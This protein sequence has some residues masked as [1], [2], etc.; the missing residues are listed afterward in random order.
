MNGSGAAHGP[1]PLTAQVRLLHP[2]AEHRQALQPPPHT[3]PHTPHYSPSPLSRP[4]PHQV[5][6]PNGSIAPHPYAQ[7]PA[8][9]YPQG[10][11]PIAHAPG[12]SPY[13]ISH[14]QPTV[15]HMGMG[16]RPP[17]GP[18]P[19]M[20]PQPFA[21]GAPMGLN[22]HQQ[23]NGHA[24]PPQTYAPT[25]PHGQHQYPPPMQMHPSQPP[26][27]TMQP[28]PMPAY[29]QTSVQPR[30]PPV[31]QGQPQHQQQGSSAQVAPKGIP[32]QMPQQQ[33]SGLPRPHPQQTMPPGQHPQQLST[34]QPQQ[35]LTSQ[36]GS[37]RA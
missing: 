1:G 21:H 9:G 13:H 30:G 6:G 22:H 3:Q 35:T 11:L 36:D 37:H 34:N 33:R 20:H 10:Q 29:A 26:H 25:M 15:Q 28:R 24:R 31:Y 7:Q 27:P 18:L 16:S 14:G 8:H 17:H 19:P 23:F 2:A 12:H 32:V 5:H 4:M